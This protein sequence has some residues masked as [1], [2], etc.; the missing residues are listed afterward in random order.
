MA[1][2]SIRKPRLGNTT[3]SR[4]LGKK[5]VVPCTTDSD[6]RKKNPNIAGGHANYPYSSSPNQRKNKKKG[7]FNTVKRG[8]PG[9]R[10]SQKRK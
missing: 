8:K 10:K 9:R 2:R 6:C 5:G 1:K 3:R 4:S 7:A